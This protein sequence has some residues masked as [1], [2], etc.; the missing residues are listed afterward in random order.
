[1]SKIEVNEISKTSTGTEITISSPVS[2]DSPLKIKSYQTSELSSLSPSA[3][4]LIYDT[5]T[6]SLKV[7]KGTS[8]EEVG[9]TVDLSGYATTTNLAANLDESFAFSLIGD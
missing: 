9:G 5:D 6:E 8:W 7:Y 4:D 3:G 2:M 1:M